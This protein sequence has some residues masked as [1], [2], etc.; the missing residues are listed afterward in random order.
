MISRVFTEEKDIYGFRHGYHGLVGNA[1]TV[2]NLGSW[3][4]NYIDKLDCVRLSLPK[5]NGDEALRDVKDIVKTSS[6]NKPGVLVYEPLQA[7]GGINMG[8]QGF[9]KGVVDHFKGLKAVTIC[10]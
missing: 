2:T 5:S 1:R 6:G 4:S 9:L 7:K 8:P 3:S 10:D